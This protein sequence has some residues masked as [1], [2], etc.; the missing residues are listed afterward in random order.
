V[1][2]SSLTGLCLMYQNLIVRN[3]TRFP[4]TSASVHAPSQ[5]YT[6]LYDSMPGLSNPGRFCTS[7]VMRIARMVDPMQSVYGPTARGGVDVPDGGAVDGLVGLLH[8]EPEPLRPLGPDQWGEPLRA[9]R[10]DIH[11]LHARIVP[12]IAPPQ[13]QGRPGNAKGPRRVRSEAQGGLERNG[14]RP[15]SGG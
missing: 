3:H 5:P 12:G 9:L 15:S 13:P 7:L 6:N 14:M 1:I 10:V 2:D 8:R 4:Y 11:L